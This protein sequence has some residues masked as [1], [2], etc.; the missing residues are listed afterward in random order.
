MSYKRAFERAGDTLHGTGGLAAAESYGAW[1]VACTDNRD[2]DTVRPG[3]VDATLFLAFEPECGALVG[4]ID[5][6]H[7]LN[8]FLLRRG[9]H[10]GYS[11]HPGCRRRGYAR[12]MLDFA[13]N[14][15][16]QKGIERV[17]LTCDRDNL[18]SAR[19]I[20]SNGGILE[21]EIQEGDG[22]IQRY[23]ISL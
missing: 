2:P 5:I 23:W 12:A 13:L 17:L 19:V 11:V 21:D 22:F 1:L 18:A 15:C 20:R 9:G 10:I 7:R 3:L 14:F 8:D 6:R 16:R 4:M